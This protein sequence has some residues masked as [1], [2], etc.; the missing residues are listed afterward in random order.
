M[1]IFIIVAILLAGIL[2]ATDG[3]GQEG[4]G[5]PPSLV[6][7]APVA[8]EAPTAPRT[9]VGTTEPR[10][11][12]AVAGEVAGLVEELNVREG[13]A[14]ERGQVLARLRSR[15]IELQIDEARAL[16]GEIE[17]RTAKAKAD[18]Q[19]AQ[20]LRGEQILSE[21]EFQRRETEL[22][23]LRQSAL[24]QQAAIKVLQDRLARMTIRAPF[25][26]QIVAEETEVGEWLGQGDT[27]AELI[28]ISS[29]RVVVPVPE[30]ALA[31]IRGAASAEV[32]FDALPGRSYRGNV[33][34]IIPRADLAS[35]TFPVEVTIDNSDG[36]ILAGMLARATFT[37][38]S[39]ESALLIPKDALV[40]QP[41]EGDYVVKVEEGLA[42]IVP[43]QVIDTFATRYAV[44]PLDGE[45][46]AA[47]RVVIRGN[48]R[49]RPGQAV[50]EAAAGESR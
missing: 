20:R 4:K 48:E 12:A 5:P 25:S 13:E 18:V 21:E 47:D 26:G 14:V 19:R 50:R 34:A 43:V 7:T 16:L 6:D 29:V 17:A 10:Y 23:A 30:Q 27:V 46:D 8:S 15:Q 1:R 32:T 38:E 36:E 2:P 44:T 42:V 40:L 33:S 41:G 11:S 45:L 39:A 9:F 3:W 31:Q 37:G 35:R 24:R 49:L 28:D 22:A